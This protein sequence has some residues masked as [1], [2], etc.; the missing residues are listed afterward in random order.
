MLA[1]VATDRRA[2]EL[3]TKRTRLG[4]WS[5]RGQIYHVISATENRYPYFSHLIA[6]RCVVR[7][8]IRLQSVEHATTLAFVVMPDHL[9]W[10]FQLGKRANMST[11]VG[12]AKS[13]AARQLKEQQPIRGT[14][15]QRGFFDRAIR[16]EDDLV[17][18]ARYIVANPLRAG[19]VDQIGDY[20]HW[21][22]VWMV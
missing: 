16:R 19:L 17:S 5:N 1:R 13:Y 10:L 15:W 7:A 3:G 8:L 2:R 11:V 22:S 18:I 6:A 4:R 14:I 20:G 21:D 9:H 12:N